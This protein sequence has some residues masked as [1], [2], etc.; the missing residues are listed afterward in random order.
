MGLFS[1]LFGKTRAEKVLPNLKDK[2]SELTVDESDIMAQVSYTV[3][4]HGDIY[5]NCEWA[6]VDD[7]PSFAEL[8]WFVSNGNLLDE[9]LEFIKE[10]CDKQ[11]DEEQY[12]TLLYSINTLMKKHLESLESSGSNPMV[13]P[14]QVMTQSLDGEIA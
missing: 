1:N 11:N 10:E 13:K 9:T 3:D 14:T 12:M 8:L 4:S 2:S 5:I 7:I 6:T